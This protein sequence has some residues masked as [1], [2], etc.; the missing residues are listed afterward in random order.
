MVGAALGMAE[1]DM[2]AARVLEHSCGN[3]SGMGARSRGMAILATDRDAAAGQRI[4]HR[5]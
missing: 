5:P 4:G 3:I 1:D 2:A